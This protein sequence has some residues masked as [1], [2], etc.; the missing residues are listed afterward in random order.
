MLVKGATGTQRSTET[1]P[2]WKSE[3]MHDHSTRGSGQ[4]Q[5]ASGSS[6][7]TWWSHRRIQNERGN[8]GSGVLKPTFPEQR[9]R[10]HHLSKRLPENSAI[11]AAEAMA[12]TVALMF[13]FS[14]WCLVYQLLLY[15]TVIETNLIE[16][17][18]YIS[19]QLYVCEF[20]ELTCVNA[21]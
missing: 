13:D 16:S 14:H 18:D 8:G 2:H 15:W 6:R 12:I 17:T 21:I 19:I 1:Q 4:I 20:I 3:Q 11:F 9:D 7:I 10:C 5:W